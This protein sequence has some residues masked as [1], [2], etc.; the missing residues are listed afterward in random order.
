MSA[1]SIPAQE[2]YPHLLKPVSLGGIK[3]RNSIAHAAITTRYSVGQKVTDR[4]IQ[5]FASRAEG[6]ASLLI[7]EPLAVLAWQ[8]SET[9]KVRAWDDEDFDGLSRWAAAV[10]AHDSRLV[11][12]IQDPGRGMHHKGRRAYSYSASSLPD[13]LSWT[14]A[15]ALEID[16]IKRVIEEVG[17]AA[18]RLQ[19]AGFSGVELSAGHGHLIHQF[20]SPHSNARDDAYGG[21]PERRMRFLLE[22]IASVRAATTRPFA[23]MVKLPG[24][25]GVPG[26]IDETACAAL[27]EALV[28]TGEIDSF[29]FC[30][31][32][33]HRTLEDHIPDMHWPRAPHND[34]TKRLRAYAGGIPVAALGRLVEPIQAEQALADGVG[35]FVQIGRAM[36]TDPA[37][38]NKAF[39]GR[40]H[41]IRWCVSCNSCWGMITDKQ[42]IACD[43]NPRL[44]T[45][46]EVEWTPPKLSPNQKRKK[47]AVVGAGVAGLEAAWIAAGRGHDVTVLG[48]GASYGGKT[49]M[50]ARL[51]GSDQ[52]SSVY[53]YQYVMANRYGVRFEFGLTAGLDDITNLDPDEVVL[54]CG[55]QQS[56]PAMLPKD[57]QADGF[58]PDLRAASEMLLGLKGHQGGTAVLFDADHTAGTYAAAQ[59]MVTLFDQVVIATPRPSIASD[60]AL[61]VYQGIHRR[62]NN[63]GVRIVSFVEPSGT[64]ALEDGIVVL[65]NVYGGPDVEI[66]NVALLTY[67]TA[68]LPNDA[69]AAPLRARGLPVHLIG[70]C[71]APRWLM[72]ATMEGHALGNKL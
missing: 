31:G 68:R 4:L 41:D 30:Q 56:W 64:S 8:T 48:A 35:D 24:D 17:D 71:Y 10:E 42:S 16:L 38:A 11:A 9:H 28:Q 65:K 49:A 21:D 52:V 61:V 6:G 69:L 45:V 72:T 20:L 18:N 39:A 57:W 53:D 40:E 36:I 19:R 58:I 33:H 32:S 62:M 37:W 50:Y 27:V 2:R 59:L 13:D 7:T 70:D 12:Q 5:Y 23:L 66:D 15:H 63:L 54:A 47:I 26:G 67:S 25:D 43:N 14:V 44:G 1:L 51:P 55:A 22:M 34:L 3:M 29:S 46:G 60:E